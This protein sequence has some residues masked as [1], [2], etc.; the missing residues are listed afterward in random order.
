MNFLKDA[1][2]YCP[3]NCILHLGL[4]ALSSLVI[5]ILIKL[6][7]GVLNLLSGDP[8]LNTVIVI[9]AMILALVLYCKCCLQRQSLACNDTPA[10][11]EIKAK[12]PIKKTPVKKTT[13]KSD[14]KK[15]T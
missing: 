3:K 7:A 12:K 13:K 8:I 4:F 9:A 6:I 5:S 14:A 10:T 11:P 15:A 2:K 1:E